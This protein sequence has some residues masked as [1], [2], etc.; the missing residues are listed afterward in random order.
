MLV[1]K[2]MITGVVAFLAASVGILSLL[3]T[4]SAPTRPPVEKPLPEAVIVY[5]FRGK[6]TPEKEMKASYGQSA[7]LGPEKN[8]TAAKDKDTAKPKPIDKTKSTTKDSNAAKTKTAASIDTGKDTAKTSTKTKESAKDNNAVKTKTKDSAKNNNAATKSTEKDAEKTPG[9]QV[10]KKPGKTPAKATVKA[11]AKDAEKGAEK[12]KKK[13]LAALGDK[14]EKYTKEVVDKHFADALA[15]GTLVWKVL[16]Y[17]S[18]KNASL[19][20]EF[21]VKKTCIVVGDARLDGSGMATNLEKKVWELVDNKEE[22]Q[23]YVRDFIQKTLKPELELE[24]EEASQILTPETDPKTSPPKADNPTADPKKETPTEFPTMGSEAMPFD[25]DA[26]TLPH[27]PPKTATGTEKKPSSPAADAT[28][29]SP[30]TK[31]PK[32]ENKK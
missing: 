20:Q 7:I 12:E 13:D 31:D 30:A 21:M 26:E 16:D 3:L 28:K 2:L 22:F 4:Q 8:I 32:K 6:D 29:E 17:Q 11:P 14:I 19:V 9:K 5:C 27:E 25:P 15:D 18:P 23:K 1:K 10:D 24:P